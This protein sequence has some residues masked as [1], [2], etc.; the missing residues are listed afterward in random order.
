M[1]TSLSSR[2]IF[3]PSHTQTQPPYYTL[4]LQGANEAASTPSPEPAPLKKRASVIAPPLF[5]AKLTAL[6]QN[7]HASPLISEEEK[8]LVAEWQSDFVREFHGYVKGRDKEKDEEV[9]L[10]LCMLLCTVI[11][12][13]MDRTEKGSASEVILAVFEAFLKRLLQMTVPENEPADLFLKSYENISYKRKLMFEQLDIIDLIIE[14]FQEKIDRLYTRANEHNQILSEK[15]TELQGRLKQIK[16][17]HVLKIG[18][19]HASLEDHVIKVEAFSQELD[20]L[21]LDIQQMDVRMKRI[22][23]TTIRSLEEYKAALRRIKR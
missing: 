1:E 7:L 19:I 5:F 14:E 15:N 12:P 4:R 11:Q 20:K 3:I 6:L 9:S 23:E 22:T 2:Q 8:D 13:A 10:A 21:H 17:H 16:S 18:R